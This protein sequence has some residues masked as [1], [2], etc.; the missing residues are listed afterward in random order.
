[1][2]VETNIQLSNN[3]YRVTVRTSEPTAVE[4]ELFQRF[5]EP[6]VETGGE[7]SG[8]VTRPG[9]SPVSVTFTLPQGQNRIF[10]DFPVV[11]V[12]DLNDTAEAD[13]RAKLYADT[14]LSRITDARDSLT[15][16]AAPFVGT[17]VVT[18]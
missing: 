5:G 11:R 9:D 2:K 14:L 1:M 10:L 8:S 16:Q 13:M 17:N 7:F 6:L 18:I 12:F 15:A 3:R 4:E